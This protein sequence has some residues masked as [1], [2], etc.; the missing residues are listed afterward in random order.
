MAIDSGSAL[1]C[2]PAYSNPRACPVISNT[3]LSPGSTRHVTR[4]LLPACATV[5]SPASS[6]PNDSSENVPCACKRQLW[7]KSETPLAD[8]SVR[9]FTSSTT[10]TFPVAPANSSGRTS[11][12][13]R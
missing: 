1:I 8:A 10:R 2:Q 4:A 12:P 5:A 11:L 7:A 3:A 13:S 9:A 6:M